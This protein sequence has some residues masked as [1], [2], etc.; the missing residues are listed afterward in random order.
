[1]AKVEARRIETRSSFV[2]SS[3]ASARGQHSRR[4]CNN[5]LRAERQRASER[6]TRLWMTWLSRIGRVLAAFGPFLVGAYSAAQD[7]PVAGA[8]NALLVL[9]VMPLTAALLSRFILET[10]GLAERG[11]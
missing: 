11:S 8:L 2:I 4:V 5:R 3:P 9:A 6:A 10:R 7:D 1:M